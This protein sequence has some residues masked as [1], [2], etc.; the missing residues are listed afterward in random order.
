MGSRRAP[1]Q[2]GAEMHAFRGGV[3]RGFFDGSGQGYARR[4]SRYPI[5]WWCF[6]RARI[7]ARENRLGTRD[8]GDERQKACQRG[9]ANHCFQR[10]LIISAQ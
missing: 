5:K 10:W 7:K 3:H 2:A 6:E 9:P 1:T 4:K 8:H